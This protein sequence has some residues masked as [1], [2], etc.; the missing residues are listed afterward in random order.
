MKGALDS[1]NLRQTFP[2]SNF[3]KFKAQIKNAALVFLFKVFSL[4][5]PFL[6]MLLIQIK[7]L[8]IFIKI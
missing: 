1:T 8:N 3:S 7:G 6:K 2:E 4:P 5:L